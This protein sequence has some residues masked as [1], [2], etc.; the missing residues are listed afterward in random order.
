MDHPCY[1]SFEHALSIVGIWVLTPH[2]LL[3]N[4]PSPHF[5]PQFMWMVCRQHIKYS[6]WWRQ[7][8]CILFGSKLKLKNA[9]KL[10]I[11]YNGTEIKQYSKVT[12]LGCL[13]NE[14]MSGESI[15]LKAI[16]KINFYIGK[17]GF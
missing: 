7:D 12:Y 17:I 8:K 5:F 14:T 1:P 3:N 13:L 10:N 15:A 11:M 9:G 6:S 2:P 4:T 16:K